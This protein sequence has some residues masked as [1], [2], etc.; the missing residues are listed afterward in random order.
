MGIYPMNSRS[1][2][3]RLDEYD[4]RQLRLV[5]DSIDKNRDGHLSYRELEEFALELG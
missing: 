2:L 1:L 5:F 4:S 3:Q